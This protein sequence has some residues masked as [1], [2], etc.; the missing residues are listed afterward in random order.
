MG[1]NGNDG[2][3]FELFVGA[4]PPGH[5]PAV[6]LGKGDVEQDEIRFLLGGHLQPLFAVGRFD[7]FVV[8]FEELHQ[9]IAVHLHIFDDQDLLHKSLLG[10]IF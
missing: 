1:G 3:L 7:Q 4:D 9:Q 6:H 5:L 8:V 2:D 10:R